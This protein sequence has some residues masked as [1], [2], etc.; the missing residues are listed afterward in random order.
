MKR[1]SIHKLFWPHYI[2]ITIWL[3]TV[4]NR[5]VRVTQTIIVGVFLILAI[6]GI[7]VAVLFT[8]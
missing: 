2:Y 5:A 4:F 1:L 7:I 8:I 3:V 6:I